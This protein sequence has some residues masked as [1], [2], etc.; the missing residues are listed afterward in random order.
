MVRCAHLYS[1]YL[2]AWSNSTRKQ[3][4][5]FPNRLPHQCERMSLKTTK[6]LW[7]ASVSFLRRLYSS[8]LSSRFLLKLFQM[9]NW[10]L[11]PWKVEEMSLSVLQVLNAKKRNWFKLRAG[12]MWTNL[13]HRCPWLAEIHSTSFKRCSSSSFCRIAIRL[14]TKTK[15]FWSCATKSTLQLRRIIL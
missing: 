7:A 3:E 15:I 1:T 14:P 13:L 4:S 12:Q 5:T 9:L 2:K 11:A 6:V 8:S 10:Q